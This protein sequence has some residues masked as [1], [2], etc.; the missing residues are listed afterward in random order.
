MTTL[1]FLSHILNLL[2]AV[3]VLEDLM[4][5]LQPMLCLSAERYIKF[6]LMSPMIWAFL[7]S[8]ALSYDASLNVF[9]EDLYL[10]SL[11]RSLNFIFYSWK[12]SRVESKED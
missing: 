1:A 9:R 5:F 11:K 3:E 4:K 10:K 12:I 8:A 6:T 2:F 7:W